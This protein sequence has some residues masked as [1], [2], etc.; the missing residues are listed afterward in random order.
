MK[1]ELLA[2]INAAREA[3][4]S[5]VRITNL[6]DGTDT[7]IVEGDAYDG[8]FA[9]ALPAAF[10]S[11]KSSQAEIGGKSYF[12]NVYVP[13]PRIVAI[14]AVHISQ[15]L[16]P[17]ARIAGFDIKIIDPRSA[18]ATEER[19]EDADLLAEWPEEVLKTSPLDSYTALAALTHDPRIDDF[20]LAEA[21]RAG[22]FYVGALGSRK[23]QESRRQRLREQGFES[24][25]LERI[26]G[27]IGLDIGAANPA[28]IA[29]SIIAEII[30]AFRLRPLS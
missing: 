27:P 7:V 11:G 24:A 16:A 17:M 22:C 14:G 20:P 2:R 13:P 12:L 23:T 5:V 29:V 4:K 30:Q 1:A 3:R 8:P 19:F 18:F 9:T 26:H 15:A 6:A 21:L 28:E 25:Q 10:R